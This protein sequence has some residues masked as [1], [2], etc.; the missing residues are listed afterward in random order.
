MIHLGFIV[1]GK[2]VYFFYILVLCSATE[3]DVCKESYPTHCF[4]DV[5][6]VPLDFPVSEDA[7]DKIC[8]TLL[9]RIKCVLD[10][11]KK[12]PNT[13]LDGSGLDEN[14]Y[15]I[16]VLLVKACDK[17]SELN[18]GLSTHLPCIEKNIQSHVAA[19]E[20]MVKEVLEEMTSHLNLSWYSEDVFPTD[21]ER[22]KYICT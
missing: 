10:Y 20:P 15:E 8:S 18:K 6:E 1:S 22:D 4:A 9:P 12:C 2:L 5:P 3:D 7:L 16:Y 13:V 11:K 19:C 21:E 17:D 14:L